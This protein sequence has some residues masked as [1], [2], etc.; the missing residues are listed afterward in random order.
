MKVKDDQ[1]RD[2]EA[3]DVFAMCIEYLKDSVYKSALSK[4]PDLQ[5]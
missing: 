2:M 4:Y 1:G 3:K 5:V